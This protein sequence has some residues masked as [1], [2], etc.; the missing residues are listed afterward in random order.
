MKGSL[1]DRAIA[2]SLIYVFLKRMPY[3]S[4]SRLRATAGVETVF[5]R[6][7][8]SSADI[9]EAQVRDRSRPALRCQQAVL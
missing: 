8:F 2:L 4:I 1:A 3:T 6:F 7:L 9:A 5:N